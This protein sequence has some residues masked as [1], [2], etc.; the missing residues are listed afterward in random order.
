M[1]PEDGDSM[2]QRNAIQFDV[3]TKTFKDAEAH[4]TAQHLQ[5]AN[6]K[7]EQIASESHIFGEYVLEQLEHVLLDYQTA[8]QSRMTTGTQHEPWTKRKIT[9]SRKLL[10]KVEEALINSGAQSGDFFLDE[11][12][13]ILSTFINET[14][15][16][17]QRE[18]SGAQ[19]IGPGSLETKYLPKVQ[20]I[21]MIAFRM[22]KIYDIHDLTEKQL[23]NQPLETKRHL[24]NV[25]RTVEGHLRYLLHDDSTSNLAKTESIL[26]D[27]EKIAQQQ[28]LYQDAS[29]ADA[30]SSSLDQMRSNFLAI[31]AVVV[32]KRNGLD[33]DSIQRALRNYATQAKNM[34]GWAACL[35]GSVVTSAYNMV[36]GAP[37]AA[38]EKVLDMAVGQTKGPGF[39][40]DDDD[41][42]DEARAARYGIVGHRTITAPVSIPAATARPH[43]T[44]PVATDRFRPASVSGSE[45][46][47]GSVPT[48][49]DLIKLD[50]PQASPRQSSRPGSRGSSN[51]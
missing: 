27:I 41:S 42:D 31:N 10:E 34:V 2:F 3:A 26:T 19:S 33:N 12:S 29:K 30:T 43:V 4:V 13:N 25:V 44:S 50:S 32:A 16:A 9:E 6:L 45:L 48:G 46:A 40:D 47:V 51:S 8:A 24:K 35:A 1:G 21:A 37:A 15:P 36:T 38:H 11:F 14:M 20:R 23:D 22:F 18:V 49:G 5:R 28:R 39:R 7:A 17:L